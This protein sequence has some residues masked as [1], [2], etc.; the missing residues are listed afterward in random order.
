MTVQPVSRD[1]G[2]PGFAGTAPEVGQAGRS[3]LGAIRDRRHGASVAALVAGD[4]AALAVAG[5]VAEAQDRGASLPRW[6]LATLPA[7]ALLFEAYDLYGRRL[8]TLGSRT[9]ADLRSLLH[10]MLVGCV[11]LGATAHIARSGIDFGTITVFG[12]VAASVLLV[13]R[14]AVR[15]ALEQMLG[16]ERILLVGTEPAIERLE[17]RLRDRPDVDVVAHV[18]AID[19][20]VARALDQL[21]V[22]HIVVAGAT[23][24]AETAFELLASCDRGSIRLSLVAPQIEALGALSHIEATQGG[25]LIALHMGGPSAASRAL[26]RGIDVVGAGVALVL[27]GPILLLVAVAIRIDSRGPALF[28]QRRVGRA[29]RSFVIWKFRTMVVD[30]EEQRQ[31]LIARSRDPNWLHLD[32]DPRITRTGRFLRRSSIDELPQLWNVL[33]GDMS[34]VGP[35]PLI[36]VEHERAPAW[37]QARSSVPPGI[38]GLWQVAGR[39]TIPFDEML[40]LDGV[41]VITW[42]LR[43]DLEILLRTVPAVVGANGAN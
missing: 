23:L 11:I 1:G 25:A 13:V 35:R 29:G 31:A 39:T 34:L 21:S 38:T 41:Y 4:L 19:G 7:W 33:R 24:E 28:P 37:A 3:L 5:L 27:L 6:V 9:T 18:A 17:R 43:R 8:R 42:S 26:K 15:R 40:R 14:T 2:S 22:D 10:A 32:D 20:V 36:A 30:A 12:V 16:P